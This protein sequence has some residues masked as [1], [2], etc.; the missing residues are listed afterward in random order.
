M[1]QQPPASIPSPISPRTKTRRRRDLWIFPTFP[2]ISLTEKGGRSLR[3]LPASRTP[4]LLLVDGQGIAHPRRFGIAFF[5]GV[6]C[7]RP[8]IGCAKS[9]LIGAAFAELAQSLGV[10][11]QR[12]DDLGAV[13]GHNRV[14]A[15]GLNEFSEERNIPGPS[16]GPV[17]FGM[18][19]G[20]I[21]ILRTEGP[22]VKTSPEDRLFSHRLDGQ[23]VQ[24]CYKRVRVIFATRFAVG[25]GQR[26]YS[27]VTPSGSMTFS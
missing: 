9:R 3:R 19:R 10:E 4:D 27:V 5:L 22:A 11:P 17:Y 25:S 7:G 16:Q 8:S 26:T 14:T 12:G 21:D 1:N 2:A 15:I 18:R 6:L 20:T 13:S 23:V 24:H